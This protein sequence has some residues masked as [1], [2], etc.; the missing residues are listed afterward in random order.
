M[1]SF[2][3]IMGKCNWEI[4]RGRQAAWD[5]PTS[6]YLSPQQL[7]ESN[8]DKCRGRVWEPLRQSKQLFRNLAMANAKV[9]GVLE[10]GG[11]V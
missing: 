4:H 7:K 10:N 11:L 1:I 6:L 8:R 5:G 9:A 2:M 3:K